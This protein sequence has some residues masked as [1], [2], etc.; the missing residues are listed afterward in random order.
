M[1]GGGRYNGLVEEL[2]GK[3]TEGI[4]FAVGLER[5]VMILKAQNKAE[6]DEISP[7]IFVASIG[8]TADISAQ[9]LVYALRQM[10]IS[11]ERDLCERSVKAQ[12]KFANKLGAKYTMVLGDDEIKNK[13]ADI[14]NMETGDSSSIAIDADEIANFIK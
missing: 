10:G 6:C 3:A 4:G 1:C 12:M 9:K 5:L 14:K 13:C 11:A 2:G 8:D 7:D